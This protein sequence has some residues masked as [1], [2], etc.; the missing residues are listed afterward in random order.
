[1]QKTQEVQ[2]QQT[3]IALQSIQK[4]SGQILTQSDVDFVLTNQTNNA[5][6]KDLTQ[7]ST[8]YV[9]IPNFTFQF[10]PKNSL[11]LVQFNLTLKGTGF[12]AL[13][14]NGQILREVPFFNG[15]FSQ[16]VFTGME[17]F[18]ISTNKIGLAWKATNG[19]LTLGSSKVTS[20]YNRVQVTDFNS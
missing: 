13:L 2:N 10:S 4:W 11:A 9:N 15:S 17:R 18:S 20:C 12:V 7:N 19:T 8:S 5:F 6:P 16:V 14:I 3:Y 1:V